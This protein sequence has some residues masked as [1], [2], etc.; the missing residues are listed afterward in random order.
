MIG[1]AFSLH[2]WIATVGAVHGAAVVVSVPSTLRGWR[3]GIR[4]GLW[5]LIGA[6]LLNTAVLAGAWI[7]GGRP[8]FKTLFETLV[9]YPW[10]I[11]LVTLVLV[12]MHRLTLMVPFA[13]V[14]CLSGIG[15]ALASPD[16]ER[17]L[18]PPALQSAWFVPHVTTYFI[19]YAAL[20]ASFVLALLALLDRGRKPGRGAELG[21]H[22]HRAALFGLATLTAGLVMGGVWGKFAWGDWWGWDPKENWALVTWLAYMIYAHLR[23]LHGW[24]GRRAQLVLVAAFAAVMFTYLGMGVLPTAES[25]MHVYQ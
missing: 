21:T 10:C 19:S 17:V 24:S 3:P 15:Y 25:S 2:P 22:A 11:A 9:F 1:E 14:A 8:P 4:T 23:L 13:A 12:A 20:F 6:F 5:L 18:L 16:V 7:E